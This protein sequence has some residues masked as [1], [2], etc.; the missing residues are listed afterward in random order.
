MKRSNVITI[1]EPR[2]SEF[3]RSGELSECPVKRMC[4]DGHKNS[5]LHL[6]GKADRQTDEQTGKNTMR[7]HE[8]TLHY[9]HMNSKQFSHSDVSTD[10]P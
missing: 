4:I 6:Y 7:I 8:P 10:M 9:A 5:Y 2:F 3:A 1:L